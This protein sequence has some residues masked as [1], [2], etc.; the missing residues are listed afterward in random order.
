MKER[1]SDNSS[2]FDSLLE[3]CSIYHGRSL[4]ETS[5]VY[6]GK[7]GKLLEGI[8]IEIIKADYAGHRDSEDVYG[9]LDGKKGLSGW[10]EGEKQ[11]YSVAGLSADEAAA[12]GMKTI[13]ELEAESECQAII[14]LAIEYGARIE[15]DEIVWDNPSDATNFQD[16][17]LSKLGI[18]LG[19]ADGSGAKDGA[20][21]PE[22][23]G[24]SGDTEV[25]APES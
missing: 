17:C 11:E 7:D 20:G 13:K 8:T 21:A 25:D 18:H 15:G 22:A 16:N 4:V 14:D 24:L 2:D 23:R 3:G 9:F 5:Q 10:P 1:I 6:I 12:L 19:A